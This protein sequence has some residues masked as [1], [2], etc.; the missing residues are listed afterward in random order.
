MVMPPETTFGERA[1]SPPSRISTQKAWTI[2]LFA[3]CFLAMT[4]KNV[5]PPI[6]PTPK[7]PVIED[8]HGVKVED[9]Y[10]WLENWND[11]AVRSWNDAENARARAFLDALPARQHIFNRLKA[12]YDQT[13]A[14]YSGLENRHG[15]LFALK[16]QPPKQQPFLITLNSEAD[17]QSEQVVVD[18]NLIDPTGGTAIDFYVPSPDGR[19]VAVSMSQ[20]GSESGTVRVY[21]VR[22]GKPLTDVISRVN[23]GT[24]GG[25][26]AWNGDGSGFYYT[27]YPYPGERPAADLD[28]YQQVY[29]HKLGTPVSSDTYSLGK[30]FPRIAEIYLQTSPDGHY[31]LATVANGDGGQFAH[32]LLGPNGMWIE[33]THFD[34]GVTRA[35]FGKDQAIYFVSQNDAP[36]GKILRMPLDHP[37]LAKSTTVIPESEEAIESCVPTAHYLYVVDVWGG[38]S[39]VRV[40]DLQGRERGNIPLEPV[41]SVRDL[42]ALSGDEVLFQNESFVSPPAWFRYA[43]LL[44]K[45]TRTGL[46]AKPAADFSDAE[47][48]RAFATSKDGAKVP[49]TIIQRK[50]IKLDGHNST[51]L[52]GYG[53]FDISLSPAYN[54][55]ARVW[56]D[57][58]GVWAVANLRGGGEYGEDW[59]KAGA[60]THKQNVFDDFAACAE[61]LIQA[62]YTNPLQFAIMGGSNGG[63]LMGAEVAQHPELFHAV[64]SF[65]GIYDML[66][67]ELSPNAVFNVT[68]Y[69]SVKDP[70]EFKA[71]YAYS[72]YHHVVD[73]A[74]YPAVLM[75]TGANDPRVNPMQSRKMTARL[76]AAS[77]SGLPVL[78]RTSSNAGHGVGSSMNQR[79]EQ[80][81]DMFAFLFK[82]L[83][84]QVRPFS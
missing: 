39:D 12:L 36:R 41:S 11:P 76:Q 77:S 78:L 81:T 28:F 60:L 35:V 57:Q 17:P 64:V 58:G 33:I 71:L 30:D 14:S 38:P 83:G 45:V 43:P 62:G 56:L 24:A 22:T 26:A 8:Y 5:L 31:V 9:D 54:L 44:R 52:T 49:M 16:S 70:A 67:H 13:S 68:E 37:A 73:G 4:S 3:A 50:G 59:H 21:D 7:K 42:V 29:F 79:L 15:I 53:G 74:A 18:P 65:V 55:N 72:P 63:L 75:M 2:L 46:Y 48:V 27:R 19:Q 84:V 82:E 66:R 69:G 40:F 6:P 1:K 80:A 61:Y 51:L 20:G 47:V 25:S 23:G 10:Q 34:D 32:Y